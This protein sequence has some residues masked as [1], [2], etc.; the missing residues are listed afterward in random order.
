[1]AP[2]DEIR[3]PYHRA[4]F[5]FAP[6]FLATPEQWRRSF[7]DL[8]NET[9]SCEKMDAAI[10]QRE[11]YEIAV[12]FGQVL[13][14]LQAASGTFGLEN[15]PI[16]KGDLWS[17]A[18]NSP[19]SFLADTL[20]SELI[21]LKLKSFIRTTLEPFAE[22]LFRG[23]ECRFERALDIGFAQIEARINSRIAEFV[24]VD[25][26][27]RRHITLDK[28]LFRESCAIGDVDNGL[29]DAAYDT[30]ERLYSYSVVLGAG[31]G[32]G[33]AVEIDRRQPGRCNRKKGPGAPRRL[34]WDVFEPIIED[35]IR[36]NPHWTQ[37]QVIEQFKKKA[38]ST[39]LRLP[40]KTALED[41]VRLFFRDKK[42]PM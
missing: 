16:A 17:W 40:A 24:V 8:I 7:S 39:K 2:R 5:Y 33:I 3:L 42:T 32:D 1:M 6:E 23:M 34:R 18:S 30:G 22:G 13:L 10:E 26:Q 21:P 19:A 25:P 38:T 37:A 27:D 12:N 15:V 28:K 20:Y 14:V 31:V 29:D 9:L 36:H 4:P 41:K 11:E 35:I